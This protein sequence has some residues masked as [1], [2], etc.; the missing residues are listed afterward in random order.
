RGSGLVFVSADEYCTSKTCCRCFSKSEEDVT[1]NRRSV[2]YS[3]CNRARD[4]DH[5]GAHNMARA[6]LQWITNKWPTEL[7][8]PNRPPAQA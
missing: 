1:M 3:R 6:D 4:H 7:W 8:R 2:Q 5:N